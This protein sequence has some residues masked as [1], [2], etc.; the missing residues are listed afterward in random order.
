MIVRKV[1]TAWVFVNICIFSNCI[2]PHTVIKIV[3][4]RLM[5]IP[6]ICIHFLLNIVGPQKEKARKTGPIFKTVV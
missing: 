3:D 4:G 6:M 1:N 5:A 2:D